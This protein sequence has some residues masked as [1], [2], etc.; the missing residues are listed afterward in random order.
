MAGLEPGEFILTIYKPGYELYRERIA[1]AA[2]LTNMTIR[3]PR[4]SG[5][6]LRARDAASGK[7]LGQL[8]AYEMIGDRNGLRLRVPL[9]E[10]GVGYIPG[11]LEGTTIAFW[12]DGYAQQTISSW[13]GQRLDLKFARE[14][15]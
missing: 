11:G 3:L 10:D 15:R 2:P 13:N 7:P 12:A 14:A 1:Y 9:D 8:H 4:G 6:Q 5:V